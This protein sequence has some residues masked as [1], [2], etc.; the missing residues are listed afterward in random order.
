VIAV[1]RR[2]WLIFG[3]PWL[4]NRRYGQEKGAAVAGDPFDTARDRVV[5]FDYW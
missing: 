2:E 1:V 3:S 5:S 4:L